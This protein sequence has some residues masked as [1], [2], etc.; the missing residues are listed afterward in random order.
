VTTD[1]T[2]NR[3][4]PLIPAAG[5]QY[6]PDIDRLVEAVDRLLDFPPALAPAPVSSSVQTVES[7]SGERPGRSHAPALRKAAA[8][9]REL[10][11][12]LRPEPAPTAQE[13]ARRAPW[14]AAWDAAP[15]EARDRWRAAL[16]AYGAQRPALERLRRAAGA[17]ERRIYLA[18]LGRLLRDAH[19]FA[20]GEEPA[21]PA[22]LRAVEEL[23]TAWAELR[24]ALYA[25][26]RR[27]A[28]E[29]REVEQEA[30]AAFKA[31]RQVHAEALASAKRASSR[32]SMLDDLALHAL[33]ALAEAVPAAVKSK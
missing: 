14:A 13:A 2:P 31:A 1:A 4:P 9:A 18:E 30:L 29:A 19:E 5:S 33:G 28:A 32:A 16:A 7:W 25:E 24:T 20:G 27:R 11:D 21:A 10:I 6:W 23:A 22:P 8:G 17:G 26:H 15:I 12:K 3:L